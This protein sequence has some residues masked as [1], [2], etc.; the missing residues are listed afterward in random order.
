M[1]AL[2]HPILKRNYRHHYRSS[3]DNFPSAL[4]NAC[5]HFYAYI[6]FPPWRAK[7]T[8]LGY[9]LPRP[10]QGRSRPAFPP[11]AALVCNCA[12]PSA[13]G[14]KNLP[15]EGGEKIFIES[16]QDSPATF[17]NL[18]NRP[19]YYHSFSLT[20]RMPPAQLYLIAL[21]FLIEPPENAPRNQQ[22]PK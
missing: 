21:P 8:A 9:A 3:A 13:I 2:I 11:P 12:P 15:K 16:C 10:R 14:I 5:I 20:V 18:Q 17:D 4:K 22:K 19:T 1:Q 7:S 6:H